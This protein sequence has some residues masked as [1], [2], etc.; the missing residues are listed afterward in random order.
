MTAV[1]VLTGKVVDISA[2]G[3]CIIGNIPLTTFTVM[4]WRLELPGVPVSLAVLAQVR[5]VKRLSP[6]DDG[7]RIG[8]SFLT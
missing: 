5:W 2:N 3:A 4:P 6:Q 8:L 1:T 7:F